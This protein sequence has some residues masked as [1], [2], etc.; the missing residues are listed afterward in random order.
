MCVI[1]LDNQ[2]QLNEKFALIIHVNNSSRKTIQL[3]L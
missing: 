1:K 2:S 3:N